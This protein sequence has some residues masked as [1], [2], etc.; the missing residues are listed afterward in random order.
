M[1]NLYATAELGA[2]PIITRSAETPPRL[3]HHQ[4]SIEL[5]PTPVQQR[6]DL[7]GWVPENPWVDYVNSGQEGGTTGNLRTS[8]LQQSHTQILPTEHQQEQMQMRQRRMDEM[9]RE[10][11]QFPQQQSNQQQ[12]PRVTR[13]RVAGEA[14]PW[15]DIGV[16]APT[17]QELEE[18]NQQ[19]P[20]F[21]ASASTSRGNQVLNRRNQ[22]IFDLQPQQQ[23]TPT[24]SNRSSSRTRPTVATM[25]RL[26]DAGEEMQQNRRYGR[27]GGGNLS[28]QEQRALNLGQ[29]QEQQQQQA[30]PVALVSLRTTMDIYSQIRESM[31]RA[32]PLSGTTTARTSEPVSRLEN[33][34]SV[35]D[36]RLPNRPQIG[37]I[38][39][40]SLER[41]TNNG[42]RSLN[43]E[44]VYHDVNQLSVLAPD[45]PNGQIPSTTFNED[46]L[47]DL[48]TRSS[49]NTP[50]VSIPQTTTDTPSNT[51]STPATIDE[52]SLD[53]IAIFETYINAHMLS[54]AEKHVAQQ[55]HLQTTGTT[56]PA[57]ST[58]AQIN[59]PT[60]LPPSAIQSMRAHPSP[61]QPSY[62]IDAYLHPEITIPRQRYTRTTTLDQHNQQ[63]IF[64]DETPDP[65]VHAQDLHTEHQRAM[66]QAAA[67]RTGSTGLAKLLD[68]NGSPVP[69]A[70]WEHVD[71]VMKVVCGGNSTAIGGGNG[72][73]SP[74]SGS[75]GGV[76]VGGVSRRRSE[77]LET[78]G[79]NSEGN[80]E[81]NLRRRF[82]RR[83]G[84]GVYGDGFYEEFGLW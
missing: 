44:I 46:D 63:H 33:I 79:N 7:S 74:T 13:L 45:T 43:V 9:N 67:I 19:Q 24:D 28:V 83:G 37:A 23:A 75:A 10:D 71:L 50:E 80:Q 18:G 76:R 29:Q 65:H 84:V 69:P 60:S 68:L 40:P 34:R 8:P 82:G 66:G 22:Q 47:P 4:G 52:T 15:R 16:A 31:Q 54:E 55:S 17:S 61:Y 57:T 78:G 42:R 21:P 77:E 27:D 38:E 62:N 3:Q 26:F 48:L 49:T 59:H 6:Q 14:V 56:P 2:I 39:F 58:S 35:I 72:D 70:A 64:I 51:F 5:Q 30:R 1:D 73:G 53:P 32:R 41:T 12:Q 25:A 11:M 20:V 81:R 36:A